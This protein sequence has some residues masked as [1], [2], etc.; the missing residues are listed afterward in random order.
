[1]LRRLY[2]LPLRLVTFRLLVLH[3][4]LYGSPERT[5]VPLTKARGASPLDEL[6]EEGVLSKN[7]LGEHLEQVPE[8]TH[9]NNCVY[10]RHNAAKH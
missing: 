1:M 3:V 7:G 10:I 4:S 5:D 9:I 2:V 8:N 6:Q